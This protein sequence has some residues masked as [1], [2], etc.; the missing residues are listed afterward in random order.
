[1][2]DGNGLTL[3]G[4]WDGGRRRVCNVRDAKWQLETHGRGIVLVCSNVVER[5]VLFLC[6]IDTRALE[7]SDAGREGEDYR[8]AFLLVP[9]EVVPAGLGV[10]YDGVVT[11]PVDAA[12][13]GGRVYGRLT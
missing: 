3:V 13:F 9:A 8:R 11:G 6:Q 4:R 5:V 10:G 1:M 2:Q 12:H 7:A